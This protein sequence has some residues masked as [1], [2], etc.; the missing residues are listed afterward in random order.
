[1]NVFPRSMMTKAGK[2]PLPLPRRKLAPMIEPMEARELLTGGTGF[3]TAFSVKASDGVAT[4][5]LTVP[6]VIKTAPPPTLSIA[7]TRAAAE[8]AN[9][10]LTAGLFTLTRAGGDL[11][12]SLTV[13]YFVA[14]TATAGD[15][16]TPLAGTVTFLPGKSTATITLTAVNDAVADAGETVQVTLTADPDDNYR[17][18]PTRSLATL[19]IADNEPVVS[20][21]ATKGV[22]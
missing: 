4:S 19:T 6:V 2:A 9:P 22:K 16:F 13:P 15:D 14:G 20:V 11:S 12:Q 8:S 3:L 7:A 17:L 5:S 21:A 18:N 1:M 10:A